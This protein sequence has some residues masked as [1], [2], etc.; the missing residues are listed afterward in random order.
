[1]PKI[2][3][4]FGT[5]PEAIK[6]APVIK[7][8]ERRPDD[9]TSI[10]CVTAQHREMLD[11]VLSAFKIR[12]H[13]DLDIMKSGQ[14]P[15][16]ITC[17]VLTGLRSVIEETRPDLVLV[18]GDT[19]TTMAAALASFYFRTKVGHVEAGLRTK[20]KFAPYPEE[21]NRR[22]A[23]AIADLHFAPTPGA[24]QNLIEEAVDPKTIHV[25]GNTVVDALFAALAIIEEDPGLQDRFA[26]QFS[27]LNP[28]KKLIVV[29]GHRRENFGEGLQNIC[30]ALAKVAANHPEVQILYPVHL[31]P[32]VYGPV[33][34]TLG[35][36]EGAN[37]L[38]ID[39][40]EYLPFVYLMNR[41]Y[42]IVTDSGGIQEEAPSLGKPVLVMRDVT[43]RPEGAQAGVVKLIG[44]GVR[45]I[46]S[47]ISRLISDAAA[48]KQ[49]TSSRNPYGDGKAAQRIVDIIHAIFRVE[50]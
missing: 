21:M 23:G 13:Y 14:D 7:E 28:H 12:P 9:F 46:Y 29:T 26:E 43:E 30:S 40:V 34:K 39:P 38:L 49:M 1:M 37:I 15:L 45:E 33:R 32:N 19:T 6:M 22:V 3:S 11:Q 35:N 10:V 4:I 18:H 27:Y 41:S 24:R 8:L 31:N 20:N 47:S 42:M 16:Q 5:R 48:Y 36:M 25:T 50:R 2:L 44:T 17:A